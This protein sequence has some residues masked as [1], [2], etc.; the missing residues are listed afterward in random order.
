M[1]IADKLTKLAT[2]ITNAYD[3][4]DDKGG[5]VP[6][7]KNTDNLE[8]A[9]RSIQTG[10][11][12][13]GTKQITQNGTVDVS[14]YAS[15]NVNVPTP[16]PSLQNKSIEITENGTQTIT[17]DSGYDGLNEVEVT[18]NVQG[19]SSEYNTLINPVIASNAG[20]SIWF[21]YAILIL[22]ELD[23]SSRTDLSEFFTNFQKL[24]TILGIDMSNATNISYMFQNCYRL[25]NIPQFNAGK[26]INMSN[27]FYNC[28]RLSNESLNNILAMCANAKS[29]TSNKTLK[30]IGLNSTQATTCQTLSNWS[31]A[32]A[33]GWTT[34]Y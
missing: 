8:N 30:Y 15:A 9:I 14:N 32:E 5:T 7:N 25:E 17:A 21:K 16:T 4:I 33:A 19:S 13:T 3:A 10:V 31:A 6:A 34:G 22:P 12:P 23:F 18:T 11:T 20:N 1:A 29:I 24:T 26:V 28:S 2:D 27:T